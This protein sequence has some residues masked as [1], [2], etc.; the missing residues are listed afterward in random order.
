MA[1][2]RELWK[3]K[4]KENLSGW[5]KRFDKAGANSAYYFLSAISFTPIIQAVHSGDWGA[6]SVL[7]M[8]LGGAVG[9][10]LLANMVQNL[11]GKSEEEVAIILT[12]E[13]QA[14]P[15]LKTELDTLLE[16]LKTL[17][18]AEKALSD[19]DKKWFAEALQRELKELKSGIS[20]TATLIGNGAIAQGKGAVAVGAGAIY[21]NGDLTIH[22]AHDPSKAEEEKA[23]DARHAYLEKL[24]RYCQALPLA[25]LGGQ[26][27][28]DEEITL[29]KVYTNLDTKIYIKNT[30]LKKLRNGENVKLTESALAK[31]TP[32]IQERMGEKKDVEPLPLWDA[33][34]A[35]PRVVVL[36]DPG[37][38][39]STFVR[40]LLGLQAA[41]LLKETAPLQGF[42][43]DLLPIM[44]I[45]RELSLRLAKLDLSSLSADKQ[46]K[47]LLK[48]VRAHLADDLKHN[49]AEIFIP[50]MMNTLE[51]GKA[52][53]V[54]DGLDEVPQSM[55]QIIRQVVLALRSEYQ[56]ER[57]IITSRIRS[58]T[59][60]AVFENT[61]TFTIR[62]FDKEKIKDFVNG[63]Y[64]AQAEMG[65]LTEKE[66][67]ERAND[68]IQATASHNLLEIASNPMMLTSMAIIH[69]KEIGLPRERVRL[70]KLVV[71][72]L[73]NRW[74]KYR[75]G[76][77]NLTPS[78]ALTAFLMDEIRLL[79]ALERLA[80]E[81]HRAGKGE[82]ES[83]DLPRLK[84]LDILEDKEYLGKI[85]LAEE[86]LDYVDQRAGLLK[87]NGGELDKPTSYS[88]PH[89]TFQ[90]YLAGCYMVRDRN[91]SREY[92]QRA[93]EGDYW[94]LAA[95]LGAE[96][97]YFNRRGIHSLLDLA[98]QL[99]PSEKPDTEQEERAALWSGL[100]A[101]V[102]GEEE[103]K[104]DQGSQDG[105]QK[106][107]SRLGPRLVSLM[108]GK[109]PPLERT[110]AGRTLAKMGDPRQDVLNPEEMLFC[111]VPMG[112]FG[113]GEKDATF[114]LNIPEFFISR[115][116]ITN[117]QYKVFMDAGGYAQK[118]YWKEA[119]QL[120][121]WKE[122][123]F[124]RRYDDTERIAPIAYSEPFHLSNHPVVGIS[125]YE[126]LAFARWMDLSLQSSGKLKIWKS[127]KTL[128]LPKN[129][130]AALPSEAEWEKAARG[131]DGREYPWGDKFDANKVNANETGIN[132]T[133][134]V[135]CFPQGESPYS[136]L[137][138]SG[139]VW[140]WTRSVY[141]E[142]PYKFEDGR[143]DLN[144]KNPRVLRGGA[145]VSLQN[146]V[147]W[148]YRYRFDPYYGSLS[149][150]FRLVVSPS[151]SY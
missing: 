57:L 60:D 146:Y 15:E 27:S 142:Y 79:S 17:P 24:R 28:T 80:Y 5:K 118:E 138:L 97:L 68:L 111:R 125:W 34:R 106:Y 81:A 12:D 144:S 9:T 46:K 51:K 108:G 29:D 139:N 124:K 87:G 149:I 67:Q 72:V 14:A 135:G 75:F 82:K 107:L 64:R 123:A 88:F 137:D 84:A 62:P 55:R 23:N 98:Y 105:G 7:G 121:Y 35:T 4:T 16:K 53:L 41:V 120:K 77:K 19:N 21:T 8:T 122:G 10:N 38:G 94:A 50:Q 145:F 103:I 25:A 141:E 48:E 148:A 11:K 101:R 26:E 52:L 92:F 66:K 6:L 59:G 30:V 136:L 22:E 143:E 36:G 127:E 65:R 61:H 63:W 45:L 114:L 39:K 56:L 150:G 99:L 2:N 47:V 13:M 113:M 89:R 18:E 110:E 134:A 3:E 69:Q 129:Y 100:I 33:V 86:F 104:T 70:Y 40:K 96:E 73:L 58:Y 37:A 42:D 112:E 71:D 147:R 43:S 32:E 151:S 95:Q 115:Y 131:T 76:E 1:L 49:H 90:E 140:E 133:S 109:L 74:Q 116:P 126:A 44:V 54:L 83:A 128:S 31:E 117:A 91:P 102:A 93:G 130:H 85:G 78:S 119:E 20:Y 132:S